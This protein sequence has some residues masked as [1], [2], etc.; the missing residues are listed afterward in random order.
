M[1][2]IIATMSFDAASARRAAQWW[3]ERLSLLTHTLRTWPWRDTAHT[4]RQR[5]REDHLALTASSLT[6]TTT[7]A[8]VPMLTV[9]LAAFT[10]FPMFGRFRTQLERYFVQGLVPDSIA[11]PVLMALTQFSDKASRLGT[12]SLVAL[13]VSALMLM[14]TIDRTLNDIWRV[15]TPR[16]LAQRVLVYW[17]AATLGPLLLGFSL[18]VSS[19]AISAS[20]GWVGALPDSWHVVLDLAEFALL[21]LAMTGLYRVVPNTHVTWGHASAGGLFVAIGF[22]LAK[23]GLALYLG[24]VPVYSTIYGAFSVVPIF[25]IWLYL[26]WVIV[27]MGAVIAAYAPSIQMRVARRPD[28][29]G[30]AFQLG[31]ILLR[32]LVKARAAESRGCSLDQLSHTLRIDPLQIEP[33]LEALVELDLVGRLDEG[34]AAR[35]VLLVDP[36]ETPAAPL[37]ARLLLRP[38]PVV[39]GLW[40]RAG[41]DGLKLAD[42]LAD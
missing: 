42:V 17:A 10:A 5:F 3:R 36:A 39:N 16:P 4:L 22:E 9:M 41:L 8:L 13:V 12:V 25:L 11:K 7:I 34:G 33:V 21:G 38:A 30:G 27:L 24:K 23:R 35:Y 37:I 14:L 26:S 6:F 32:E 15:R 31:A 2:G 1:A 20:R 19:Y 18:S 28:T 29:P 40:H